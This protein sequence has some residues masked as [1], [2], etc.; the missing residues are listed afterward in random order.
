MGIHESQSRLWENVVGRS[1]PFWEHYLPELKRVFP[2]QLEGVSLDELYAAV[3]VVE[4]SL[5]RVEAD[6]VTYNLHILVR[7]ELETALISG[8]LPTSDLPSAWREKMKAYLGIEPKTDADGCLQDIHWAWGAVGYFPT[9]SLGNL[10]SAQ[11]M[12]A[13][14]K[15]HPQVWNDVRRGDFAPLLGW[16]RK[17]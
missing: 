5:V 6:E 7:F 17:N 14:E 1:R 16:L 13:Y 9:Y 10:W 15:Q 4:P 8:D 12:N 2:K 3:N 11:L